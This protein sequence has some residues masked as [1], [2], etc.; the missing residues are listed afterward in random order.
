M[1]V[2]GTGT[3]CC[4]C[5]SEI[6]GCGTPRDLMPVKWVGGVAVH[7]AAIR[8]GFDNAQ[9]DRGVATLTPVGG[10]TAPGFCERY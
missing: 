9:A 10:I 5:A 3:L 2:P 7:G 8:R 4:D 6:F 1:E